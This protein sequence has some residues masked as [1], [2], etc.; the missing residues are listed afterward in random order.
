MLIGSLMPGSLVNA[1]IR[2]VLPDGLLVSFLTYFN[3]SID[4]FHLSQVC[5]PTEEPRDLWCHQFLLSLSNAVRAFG[6]HYAA[7][8]LHD[9]SDRSYRRL[10]GRAASAQ[11]SGFAHVSSLWTP[12]PRPSS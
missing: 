1:R 7:A 2:N 3:G 5:S 8:E 12:S 10:I 6:G 9:A 4:R 11:G